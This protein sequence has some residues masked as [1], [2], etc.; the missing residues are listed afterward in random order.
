MNLQLKI[1]KTAATK[2]KNT[3]QESM[4]KEGNRNVTFEKGKKKRCWVSGGRCKKRA[5]A[6]F[7]KL[8]KDPAEKKKDI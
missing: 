6:G 7:A 8:K 5:I 2:F 4:N 3:G 1:K